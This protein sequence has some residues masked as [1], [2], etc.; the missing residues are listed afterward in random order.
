MTP[1]DLIMLREAL[2]VIHAQKMVIGKVAIHSPWG[3]QTATVKDIMKVQPDEIEKTDWDITAGP[4]TTDYDLMIFCNVFHYIKT[5]ARAFANVLKSCRYLLI[6]DIIIRDRGVDG[7][8]STDGDAMR[9]CIPP[10]GSNYGGAF[11]LTPMK[12]RMVF[13]MPYID[14]G[15]AIHFIALI[16]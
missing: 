15:V 6:Q 4:H 10:I 14:S 12:D 1:K 16:K 3:P 9:Y 5:P 2:A 13:F 11:D 8:L 7:I